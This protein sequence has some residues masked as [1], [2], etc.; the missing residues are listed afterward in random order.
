MIDLFFDHLLNIVINL[1]YQ[2]IFTITKEKASLFKY[3]DD[4][5]VFAT[6]GNTGYLDAFIFISIN[7]TW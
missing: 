2:V 1:P 4:L 6:Q 3:V 7:D 5:S